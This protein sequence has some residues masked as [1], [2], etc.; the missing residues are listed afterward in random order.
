MKAILVHDHKFRKINGQFYSPGGLPDEVLQ[1]YTS[2]FDKII[3]IGRILEEDTVN[4]KYN[5]IT[6]PNVTIQTSA[7][8]EETISKVDVVI[9]RLPSGNGT[10]AVK[11]A[12]QLGKPYLV[13]VVGCP[14][15]S[16]WNYNWKGKI[17]AIPAMLKMRRAVRNAPFAI[18]VTS[19]FLQR[20]YPCNGETVNISNVNLVAASKEVLETRLTKIKTHHGP[21]VV[22]TAAALDVPYKGQGFV[23]RA[24][25]RLKKKG[26]TNFKYQV[27]GG[28]DSS[29]LVELAKELGVADQLEIIGLLTRQEM[30]SWL[31]G[32][33]I[34]IQPSLQEGLPRAVIEAMGRG[35]PCIGAKTGGIPELLDERF[36][37]GKIS[38]H[39]MVRMIAVRLMKIIDNEVLLIQA[40]RNFNLANSEYD[41]SIL[42]ERRKKIFNKLIESIKE[43]N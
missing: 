18:Y 40:A 41:I 27:A 9:S 2:I 33:D 36:V 11:I 13:E 34:Y 39:Y 32:L 30:A 20:R 38:E 6:T 14:F 35:L 25:A 43:A 1:R 26:I 16:L 7:N 21:F 29:K 42:T 3:V 31:D 5:L 12:K 28:G 24:L 22:G 8:L 19:D 4:P 17:I 37:Y 15:D 23:I 10:K